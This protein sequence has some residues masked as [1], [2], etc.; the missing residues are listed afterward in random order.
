MADPE[1]P[2]QLASLPILNRLAALRNIEDRTKRIATTA[3]IHAVLRAQW[4]LDPRFHTSIASHLVDEV[5]P[6]FRHAFAALAP[7][8]VARVDLRAFALANQSLH[9][10]HGLEDRLWFPR[11]KKLHPE[12]RAEI[13]ILEADHGALVALEARIRRGDVKAL[14]EFVEN[15][16]DHLNREEMISVPFL[17]DGTGGLG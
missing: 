3:A 14:R 17:M 9:Q 5:H 15:L 4:F 6:L 12:M 13:E 11:L 7:A 8:E 2:D 16:M 10:H 1:S